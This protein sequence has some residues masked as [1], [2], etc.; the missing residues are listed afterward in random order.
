[1]KTVHLFVENEPAQVGPPPCLCGE[2]KPEKA[3][4]AAAWHAGVYVAQADEWVCG[5]CMGEVGAR[6]ARGERL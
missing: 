3:V 5:P 6:L 2:P 4:R 1:M